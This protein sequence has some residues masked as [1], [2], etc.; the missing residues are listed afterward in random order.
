MTI[1]AIMIALCLCVFVY[2]FKLAHENNV[3]KH[4]ISVAGK[5]ET[6]RLFFIS[7]THER[8]INEQMIS[9]IIEPIDLVIIGGDFVDKRT[10]KHI[11]HENIQLLKTLG[12][13]YFV[14][15]NNDR[16]QGENALRQLFEE[17]GVTIIE[18]QSI[19]IKSKNNVKISA[20]DFQFASSSVEK[21]FKNCEQQ[22]TIFIAHNPQVFPKIHSKFKPLL[23]I[24]A[25][26]HGGQIRLG[27]FGIQPHGYFAKKDGYYELVSNGYGT[28][29]VPLR[30]GAKPECHLIEIRFS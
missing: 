26:L 30:L 10:S 25:H 22:S 27:K 11:I 5:D 16:E 19:A 18:N 12:P 28:T 29:L 8:K 3:R 17:H 21:V 7:D 15:G 2:M 20:V 23:S 6:L 4:T 24:G 9:S 1:I 13:V 14:W